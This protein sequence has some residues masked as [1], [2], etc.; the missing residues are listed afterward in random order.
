M[1]GDSLRSFEKFNY[2]LRPSKQVE[3]KLLIETFH[4]L[5][6]ANYN[7]A[8]YTYLGLGSVYFVDFV[9]LHKYL[10]IDDMIC[11]EREK[12]PKRMEFNRPYQ[13]IKIEMR[14]IAE[15]IPFLDATRRYLVWLDYDS[16]LTPEILDDID[17]F[18]QS[19]KL[20][21]ILVITVDARAQLPEEEDTPSLS[22][23]DRYAEVYKFYRQHFEKYAGGPIQAADLG[24]KSFP[25][26]LARM[27]RAKIAESMR[28]RPD[29]EFNQLFNFLYADNAPMLTI[30]GLIERDGRADHLWD[31]CLKGLEY[32]TRGEVPVE[33][34]VPP[35]TERERQWID[36]KLDK[37]AGST[38]LP[39]ELEPIMVKAYRRFARHY[40]SY[41]EAVV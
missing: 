35:L 9:L 16:S 39:F 25:E 11:V 8:R 41:H 20:G 4:R 26:L 40:P 28:G 37:S 31:G 29:C 6:Q 34:T 7:I 27:I 17:G 3:R 21:S 18:V 32:L 1:T 36:G 38:G 12:I 30:G 33:I 15:V 22:E 13:F 14:Q 19:L 10:Y 5:G 23:D 24:E 2:A